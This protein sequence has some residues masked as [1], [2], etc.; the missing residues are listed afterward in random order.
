M[1]EMGTRNGNGSAPRITR[2]YLLRHGI[3]AWNADRRFQGQLDIP[4]N[5]EGLKQAQAVARWLSEQE[6]RFSAIY[7]SDLSRAAQTA[8]T[9]GCA[10]GLDPIYSEDLR[11]IHCGEWQGL[12]VA[13]VERNYPGQLNVWDANVEAFTLP[14]GESIPQVQSRLFTCFKQT[15]GR[16]AGEAIILVSHGAALAALQAAIAGWTLAET[17]A[18]RRARLGN[19]GVSVVDADHTT[20]RGNLVLVNSVAHLERPTGMTSVLDR[21]V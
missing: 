13:E 20:G 21:T 16:H 17:W 10:L 5:E 8:E 14:G 15:V 19:T 2:V 6:P 12:S 7:S 11:E 1:S 9:V 18:D 4:L 3:T